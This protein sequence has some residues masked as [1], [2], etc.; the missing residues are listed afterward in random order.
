[1]HTLRLAL[2]EYTVFFGVLFVQVLNF[3]LFYRENLHGVSLEEL[4]RRKQAR[5]DSAQPPAE[6]I[7]HTSLSD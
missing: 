5:A 1:M 7:A 2:I 6:H 3:I 4:L